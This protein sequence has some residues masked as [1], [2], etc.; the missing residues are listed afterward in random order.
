MAGHC[1]DRRGRDPEAQAHVTAFREYLQTLY[2]E[3]LAG[4]RSGRSLDDLKR[5]IRLEK[6]R[7]WAGYEQMRELNIEGMHRYV[8]LFRI[9]NP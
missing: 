2:D 5:E 4:A 1:Q 9:P 6:Y 3:V 8:Q 7:S